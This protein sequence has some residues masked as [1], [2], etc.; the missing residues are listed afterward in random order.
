[1]YDLIDVAGRRKHR[2]K[3]ELNVSVDRLGKKIFD[4]HKLSKQ[5]GDLILLKEFNYKF[6]KGEKIG[7]IGPSL[8]K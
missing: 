3:L 6:K 2:D 4:I 1:M 7:I 5:Y 8:R